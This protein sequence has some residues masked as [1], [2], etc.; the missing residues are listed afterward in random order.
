MKTMRLKAGFTLVEMLVVI[1]IIVVLMAILFP[2]FQSVREKSRQAN[3]QANLHQIAAALKIYR[4]DHGRYP[5]APYYDTTAKRY[6]GGI[7]ALYPDEI[8]DKNLLICPADRRID[9]IE[10]EAKERLYSSYNGWVEAPTT[11]DENS[12]HFKQ[13][14]FHSA[15]DPTE[16]ITGPERYYNWFGYTQEGG[17]AYY[18]TSLADNNVPY[19]TAAPTWLTSD[20]LRLRHYPRLRNR[21]APDNTYITLCPHHREYSDKPEDE[22]DIYVNVGGTTKVVNRKFMQE[23][24]GN[25]SRWVTQRD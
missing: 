11:T 19:L 20:G 21:H 23:I 13:G 22:V 25:A 14:T 5:P 24:T 12:W 6:I 18:Y 3:C 16:E 7:S 9:G 8:S 17:D 2:V 1:S 4:T 15:E 10:K